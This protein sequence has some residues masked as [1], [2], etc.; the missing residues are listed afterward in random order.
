MAI[1]GPQKLAV[2]LCKFNDTAHTEPNPTSFYN[3]LLVRRGTGGVNDYFTAASLGAINLDGSQVFGW[4]TIDTTRDDFIA[5]HPG[6]WD[7]IKGAIDAFSDVDTSQ[8]AAV[9]AIFNV[10]LGDGGAQGGVLCAPEDANVTFLGHEIG[11]VLGLDHSFDQSTRTLMSWSMPGEYYDQHDIMSAM[12]VLSD[13]GHR[14]SPRG[15][16]LNAA[17]LQ[18]M[19]WMPASRVWHPPSKNSS[20]IYDIDLVALSSPDTPGFLAA[21]LGGVIVEFRIPE[22]FDSA[23]PRAAVLIHEPANPNSTVIA[24]NLASNNNEWQPGQTYDATTQLLGQTGGVRVHIVSFDLRRK[25]AKLRLSVM[26]IRPPLYHETPLYILGPGN[27]LVALVNGKIV[28][29]PMP[30]PRL[31]SLIEGFANPLA[32][33]LAPQA[34]DIRFDVRQELRGRPGV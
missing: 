3:D 5:A 26:A 10:G 7:K 18:R 11:H 24:S 1:K 13:A 27:T 17:N 33:S 9:V 22:G 28:R 15:P 8:F 4:T 12:N 32:H 19:E 30:D 21:E 23:I 2:L 16:L 34:N 29:V 31:I 14:F 20:G 25:V 6:R